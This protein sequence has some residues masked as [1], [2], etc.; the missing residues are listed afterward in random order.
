MIQEQQDL[1]ARISGL[2]EHEI[3]VIYLLSIPF[4]ITPGVK[5]VFTEP[6]ALNGLEE[7]LRSRK[8]WFRNHR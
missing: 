8:T 3:R 1:C 7:L 4:Q 5:E 6:L 2:I